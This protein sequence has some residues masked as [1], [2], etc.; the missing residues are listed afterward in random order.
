MGKGMAFS[1]CSIS[2]VV[3]EEQRPA[4]LHQGRL[5]VEDGKASMFS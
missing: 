1:C 5:L 4:S 3:T 2:T